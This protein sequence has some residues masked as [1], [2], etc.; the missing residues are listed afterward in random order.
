MESGQGRKGGIGVV[1]GVEGI[2][3][4]VMEDVGVSVLY[5]LDK[6][7]QRRKQL[8]LELVLLSST[9]SLL[10]QLDTEYRFQLVDYLLFIL[11]FRIR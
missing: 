1:N 3:N 9:H 2:C 7:W 5:W 11:S 6:W 4:R 8:L 10:E